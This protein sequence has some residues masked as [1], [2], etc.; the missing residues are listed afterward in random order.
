MTSFAALSESLRTYPLQPGD[1]LRIQVWGESELA[2]EVL[3]APD[4]T[5]SF[6]LVG[7]VAAAGRSADEVQS[8]LALRLEKF[9]PDANVNL[10]V[11]NTSGNVIYVLGQVARPGQFPM[12]GHFNV[13]QALSVAGGM[14]PFASVNDIRILRDRA[15]IKSTFVFRY[16]DVEKGLL[17]EQNIDLVSGDV[18]IVP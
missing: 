12:P 10:S 15:G 3:I 16:S 1:A 13:T 11:V 2:Q 17:L 5:F 18:V 6:P 14:T 9:V 8:E 4:G 7:S